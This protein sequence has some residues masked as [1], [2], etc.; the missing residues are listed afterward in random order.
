MM[1]NKKEE[2]L[3]LLGLAKKSKV[4]TQ[5]E[6]SEKII[7]CNKE[8][9]QELKHQIKVMTGQDVNLNKIPILIP[10]SVF[11]ELPLVSI[12]KGNFIRRQIKS[13][14]FLGSAYEPFVN[15]ENPQVKQIAKK[16]ARLAIN[17]NKRYE[18]SNLLNQLYSVS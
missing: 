12:Y 13:N 10:A 1:A 11:I 18:T 14:G 7:L 3:K 5:H 15:K 17:K 9:L 2:F 16:K 6:Y 4:H 8:K